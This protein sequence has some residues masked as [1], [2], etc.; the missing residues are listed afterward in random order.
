MKEFAP[1]SADLVFLDAAHDYENVLADIRAWLPIVKPDGFL[2]GHDFDRA[3]LNLI[4]DSILNHCTNEYSQVW[5]GDSKEYP[6]E[7]LVPIFRD[8][9]QIGN[10]VNVHFG[11]L[12]AVA[13]TFREVIT[14]TDISS[15][16]W[17]VKPEWE[18]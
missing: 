6:D 18:K 2:C 11:V 4:G 14:S 16:V 9:K 15:S 1:Q 13:E 10:G 3:G 7:L 5:I 17:A 12:R 8:N